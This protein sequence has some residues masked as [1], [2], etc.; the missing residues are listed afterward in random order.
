MFE[1]GCLEIVARSWLRDIWLLSDTVWSIE[2]LDLLH[3]PPIGRFLLAMLFTS[4]RLMSKFVTAF[5]P[6]NLMAAMS[7]ASAA[8]SCVP[9][10]INEF[11]GLIECFL[12]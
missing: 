12:I 5:N 3:M 1:C 10:E 4:Y 2:V 9:G 8:S 6:R 11:I 7:Y